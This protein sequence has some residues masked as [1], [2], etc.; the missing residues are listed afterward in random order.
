MQ[1]TVSG[2]LARRLLRPARTW[3]EYQRKKPLIKARREYDI[4]EFAKFLKGVEFAGVNIK[5]DEE[6]DDFTIKEQ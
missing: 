1:I 2:R 4:K 3:K 6:L 5:V